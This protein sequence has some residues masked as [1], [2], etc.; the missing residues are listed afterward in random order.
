MASSPTPAPAVVT[1]TGEDGLVT[2]SA[3]SSV[4]P[5]PDQLITVPVCRST[6]RGGTWV[7]V[8]DPSTGAKALHYVVVSR[9]GGRFLRDSSVM[10]DVVDIVAGRQHRSSGTARILPP[11]FGGMIGANDNFEVIDA[12]VMDS[13]DAPR[14]SMRC[15][16]IDTKRDMELYRGG[17]GGGERQTP[18][19]GILSPVLADDAM[20]RPMQDSIGTGGDDSRTS[21]P[22]ATISDRMIRSATNPC[23]VE[24]FTYTV[25]HE[26]K[27]QN[28]TLN[29]LIRYMRV[30]ATVERRQQFLDHFARFVARVHGAVLMNTSLDDIA[31]D[32]SWKF[33][34]YAFVVAW[35]PEA[36]RHDGVAGANSSSIGNAVHASSS[37]STSDMINIMEALH[38][39]RAQDFVRRVGRLLCVDP[40]AAMKSVARYH[41]QA[42]KKRQASASVVQVG[43]GDDDTRKKASTGLIAPVPPAYVRAAAVDESEDD[44]AH[45]NHHHPSVTVDDAQDDDDHTTSTIV[46]DGEFDLDASLLCCA[47][48]GHALADH[49]VELPIGDDDADEF[50][51]I[52]YASAREALESGA[53]DTV[54]T[55]L[56]G[57]RRAMEEG[58][59]STG[60]RM[61]PA[62]TSLEAV[63]R[64]GVTY[65]Q[66]RA[67][68]LSHAHPASRDKKDRGQ[69]SRRVDTV[70]QAFIERHVLR[71]V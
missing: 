68:E 24:A 38:R 4:P 42:Q 1:A 46:H 69:S 60:A 51:S 47:S 18:V 59:D 45:K 55:E 34:R 65:A 63:F 16:N 9:G 22:T 25:V 7:R 71:D 66:L 32:T 28:Y 39:A 17:L 27:G 20:A 8:T 70:T 56:A 35:R 31:V 44:A 58:G 14:V 40:A 21:M 2:T 52:L 53:G 3:R 11:G 29:E 48:G 33:R 13:R 61:R 30:Y 57:S 19:D 67:A 50:G 49:L 41:A 23:Q 26:I 10:T 36:V 62:V 43:S 6:G 64:D 54:Y 12:R 5:R 37:S 15:I